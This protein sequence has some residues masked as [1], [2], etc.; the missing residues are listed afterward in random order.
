MFPEEE[1]SADGVAEVAVSSRADDALFDVLLDLAVKL[2][3]D[4]FGE[5]VRVRDADVIVD[6]ALFAKVVVVLGDE[7]ISTV[8]DTAY[9]IRVDALLWLEGGGEGKVG[10]SPDAIADVF[11]GDGEIGEGEGGLLAEAE[12]GYGFGFCIPV[13]LVEL[14]HASEVPATVFDV[15][16]AVV[17]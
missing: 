1:E 6:E 4:L 12:G 17:F 3:F 10:R 11:A 16:E 2:V 8:V 5:A 9:L 15:F 7:S 13:E 14:I